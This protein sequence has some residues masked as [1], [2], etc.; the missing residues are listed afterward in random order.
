MVPFPRSLAMSTRLF[1]LLALSALSG[2]AQQTS[3]TLTG[4]ITDPAGALMPGV[5]VTATNLATNVARESKTDESGSFTIP[6]L[7]S[8][9]YS[10]TAVNAGFKT[11]K[12][13]R[14]TLQLQQ[15]ARVD[16]QSQVGDVTE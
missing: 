4:V 2:M 13:D 11:K 6:F 16:L 10:V 8:G 15:V 3:A 5:T 1:V 9:D 7:P 12:L 14:I